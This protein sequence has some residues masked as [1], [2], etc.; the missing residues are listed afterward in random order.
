VSSPNNSTVISLSDLDILAGMKRKI[1][2]WTGHA[3][4]MDQTRTL[5]V[6]E[7]KLGGSRKRGSARLRWLEDAED[8]REMKVKR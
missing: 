6:F 5:E 1:F 2:D 7:S 3:V 8:L 4:R